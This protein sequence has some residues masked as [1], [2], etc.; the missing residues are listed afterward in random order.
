MIVFG[1][2]TYNRCERLP[3]LLA[4]MAGQDIGEPFT[5]LIVDNASTDATCEVIARE[6]SLHAYPLRYVYEP[7]PGITRARNRLIR[8]AGDAEYL[9]MIDDD[10]MPDP[11]LIRHA[12]AGL[13]DEGADCVGGRIRLVLPGDRPAWLTPG[14]LSG[15][16]HLDY[17]QEDFPVRSRT[18]PLWGGNIGFR[19]SV[20][21]GDSAL[22]FDNRYNRRGLGI[23]GGEDTMIFHRLLHEGRH[24]RYCAA[25]LVDHEVEPER[26]RRTYFLKRGW[27]RGLLFGRHRMTSDENMQELRGGS[28]VKDIWWA[29]RQCVLHFFRRDPRYLEFLIRFAFGWGAVCG[30]IARF[31]CRSARET[32]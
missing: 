10:E 15:L 8:E 28:L 13:R 25:M 11:G 9:V 18:H 21:R 26:V 30:R 29:S 20:F 16:G 1:C 4:A 7:E 3:G 23:G 14:L 5:I 24:I 6:A 31:A 22:R 32:G 2:C 27:S 17:G 19:M 12:V